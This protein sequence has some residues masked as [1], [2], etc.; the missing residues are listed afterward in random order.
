MARRLWMSLTFVGGLA[1]A[2]LVGN[3]MVSAQG[4]AP[5]FAAVPGEHGGQDIWGGYEP[6]ENWPKEISDLPGHSGWTWGA[7]QAIFAESPDR[8]IGLMRGELPNIQRPETQNLSDIAP[9]L[10]FP[11][12]RLPWRD[13]TSAALPGNGGTGQSAEEGI[14]SWLERGLKMNVDARW[15]HCIVV[16]DREGNIIEEWTR[17]TEDGVELIWNASTWDPYRVVLLRTRI[18]P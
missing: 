16:F 11:I 3:Q 5:S 7:G 12:G 4:N 8:V 2:F 17:T 9:S 10:S 14:S 18:K 6:A 13:A 15:E 1:G